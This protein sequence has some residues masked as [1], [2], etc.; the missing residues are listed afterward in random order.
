MVMRRV[1]TRRAAGGSER[2]HD[3]DCREAVVRVLEVLRH[4]VL[5]AAEL[6]P[7]HVGVRD[8]NHFDV[9]FLD[10][11]RP[12]A[13]PHVRVQGVVLTWQRRHVSRDVM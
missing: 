11:H 7:F 1:T 10:A 12:A 6:H 13:V 5:I 3:V 8:R 4:A 9:V 2:A